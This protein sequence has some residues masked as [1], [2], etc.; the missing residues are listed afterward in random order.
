MRWSLGGGTKVQVW[1]QVFAIL[2]AIAYLNLGI[3]LAWL[4]EVG[5][6][7]REVCKVK[8]FLNLRGLIVLSLVCVIIGWVKTSDWVEED[9]CEI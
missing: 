2:A 7:E 6:D 4:K 9:S 5:S 1:L 3:T 8:W